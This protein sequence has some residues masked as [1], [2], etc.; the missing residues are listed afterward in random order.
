MEVLDEE[1][2]EEVL[3]PEE[4]TYEA[5]IRHRELASQKARIVSQ[6]YAK[7]QERL[8]DGAD[9]RTTRGPSSRLNPAR[10]VAA[11]DSGHRGP[12]AS[13]DPPKVRQSLFDV[14]GANLEYALEMGEDFRSPQSRASSTMTS[15]HG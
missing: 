9:E 4:G 2:Q 15:R 12:V 11:V 10:T 6:M 3:V 7:D 5:G 8:D 13:V 14:M 1:E